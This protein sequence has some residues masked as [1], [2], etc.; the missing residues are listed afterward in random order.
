MVRRSPGHCSNAMLALAAPTLAQNP[1]TG[2]S[3]HAVAFKLE[4][5]VPALHASQLELPEMGP[6]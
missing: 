3:S 6:N 1:P 2:H 5:N 4:L